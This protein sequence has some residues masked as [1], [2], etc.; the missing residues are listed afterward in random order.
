MFWGEFTAGSLR[1]KE[2]S[3]NKGLI[4]RNDIKKLNLIAQN[5]KKLMYKKNFKKNTIKQQSAVI[6]KPI[7]I[8]EEQRTEQVKAVAVAAGTEHILIL[9]LKGELFSWG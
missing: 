3:Q 1:M 4:Q 9:N 7:K 8:S 5:A 6:P 2:N